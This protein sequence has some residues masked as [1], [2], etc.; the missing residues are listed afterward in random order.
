MT[1]SIVKAP[2]GKTRD[3]TEHGQDPGGAHAD[4]G[5]GSGI[6]HSADQ[7]EQ[8]RHRLEDHLDDA[9]DHLKERQAD[10]ERLEQVEDVAG[11]WE[12][13]RPDPHHPQGDGP[14]E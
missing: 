1:P 5:G 14:A 3:M 11:D 13:K 4:E 2:A 10:A 7:L 12:E 9:K 6:E 8:D